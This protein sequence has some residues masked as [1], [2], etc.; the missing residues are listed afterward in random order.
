MF[1]EFHLN[2]KHMQKI[3]ILWI[4]FGDKTLNDLNCQNI[5][6]IELYFLKKV[7]P[8]FPCS[9]MASNDWF[10]LIDW[11]IVLRQGLTLY[12]RM[13]S[14]SWSS[15]LC[16]PSAGIIGVHPHNLHCSLTFVQKGCH[17]LL[18]YIYQWFSH[19]CSHTAIQC[20]PLRAC[21]NRYTTCLQ[22]ASSLVG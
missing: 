11:L 13:A 8:Q 20:Q 17:D 22:G 15:F 18:V 2:K 21:G 5:V 14:N 1:C 16:L 10:L 19:S 3:L 9:M 12:P 6:I 7:L 4:L